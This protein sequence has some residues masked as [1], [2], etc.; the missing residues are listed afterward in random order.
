[1]YSIDGFDGVISER[2]RPTDT[3]KSILPFLC[4]L[5]TDSSQCVSSR[6]PIRWN[7]RDQHPAMNGKHVMFNVSTIKGCNIGESSSKVAVHE[8]WIRYV[9]NYGMN[10][11]M[12]E[13]GSGISHRDQFAEGNTWMSFTTERKS[14][15]PPAV[16]I[17]TWP[18]K[19]NLF[20]CSDHSKWDFH[21]VLRSPCTA[22]RS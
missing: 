17:L 6:P 18:E 1:M 10:N 15:V 20:D 13:F 8:V 21:G 16:G 9:G 4:L 12:Q 19:G 11:D 3:Y 14:R 2:I 7:G 5:L 22:R